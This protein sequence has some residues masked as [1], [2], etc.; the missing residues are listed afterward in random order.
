MLRRGAKAAVRRIGYTLVPRGRKPVATTVYDVPT[1][2]LY[3]HSPGAFEVPT[4][5]C[6]YPYGF[7][8]DPRGWHPFVATLRELVARP[9]LRYEDSVLRTYYDAYQ[10]ASV[11]EL[12]FEDGYAWDGAAVVDVGAGRPRRPGPTVGRASTAA[13]GPPEAPGAALTAALR[14]LEGYSTSEFLPFQPWDPRTHPPRGEKGLAAS[15]GNQ[16]FGPVSAEKGQLELDRLRTTLTS[17]EQ[18]G[19]RPELCNGDEISGYFLIHEGEYRF[20]IRAGLHRVAALTVLGHERVRVTFFPGYPRAIHLSD[21]GN[22]PLVRRGVIAPELARRYALRFFEED[23][24]K[25]AASI[26]LL[27]E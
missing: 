10:P 15:H 25:K 7:S 23:G 16:G 12:L 26:G 17:I 5:R 4:E 18:H 19:Y 8:Y 22:W 24:R 14:G 20:V 11:R 1:D 27:R 6:Q 21:V 13:E 3:D 2:A 9:D